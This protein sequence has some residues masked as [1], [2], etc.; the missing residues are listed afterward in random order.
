MYKEPK[1]SIL[2]NIFL[3]PNTHTECELE[4]ILNSF[5]RLVCRIDSENSELDQSLNITIQV[6]ERT[7]ESG[8]SISGEANTHG[9]NFVVRPITFC[10]FHFINLA[11]MFTFT[12]S[13]FCTH[14]RFQKSQ[15][16]FRIMDLRLGEPRSPY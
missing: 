2:I 8:Y 10:I 3:Y 13:S 16:L 11:Y 14:I 5:L 12:D 7:V 6:N 4:M 1:N 9:F 15:I